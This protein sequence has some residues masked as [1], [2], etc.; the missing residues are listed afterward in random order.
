ML[1][2][3]KILKSELLAYLIIGGLTAF[4][5]FG[6][7]ALDVEILELDYRIAV[8]IA[9]VIAVSFHFLANR[10]FTFRVSDS[11][12]VRQF[13]RYIGVLLINYLITISIVSLSVD[14]LGVSPYEGVAASIAVTV[15][16]GYI[17][18]KFWVFR[19][20]GALRD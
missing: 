4:I 20:K 19:N 7:I 8:S 15:V 10:K 3:K 5:Y 14:R 1:F 17:V 9:Y 18:T 2:F 11:R 16:V 12:V 13:F 6:I